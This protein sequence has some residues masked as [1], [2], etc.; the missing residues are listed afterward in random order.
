MARF[1]EPLGYKKGS[2]GAPLPNTEQ[3]GGISRLIATALGPLTHDKW[4]SQ[5]RDGTYMLTTLPPLRL[6]TAA[7]HCTLP[8]YVVGGGV[9]RY[10]LQTVT[11]Y[12]SGT[13]RDFA[14]YA[15]VDRLWSE[16]SRCCAVIYERA[17]RRIVLAW[18]STSLH[19]REAVP[20]YVP[21][22]RLPGRG[23]THPG[24][25]S[26]RNILRVV[27]RWAEVDGLF[28][29]SRHVREALRRIAGA[30]HRCLAVGHWRGRHAVLVSADAEMRR[31]GVM[32]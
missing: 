8:W 27:R 1:T 16:Q 23:V 21:E 2:H 7:K 9:V 13:P 26:S 32:V 24:T 29:G 5:I 17:C 22:F 3:C 10:L 6:L 18:I 14:S 12:A 25:C 19:F 28:T 30:C 31:V 11:R 20:A 4:V 15:L